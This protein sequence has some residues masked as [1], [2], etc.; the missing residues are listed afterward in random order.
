MFYLNLI[1]CLIIISLGV[2]LYMFSKK[3]KKIIISLEGNIGAGKSTMLSLLKDELGD[4]C[5]YVTEPVNEWINV[6]DESGKNILE[7]FYN[8]RTRWAYTFENIAYVTRLC[9]I[10]DKLLNSDKKYIIIDRSPAAGLNVFAKMSYDDKFM[11]NIEWTYLNKWNTFF[12][13]IFGDYFDHKIVYLECD[14]ETALDRICSRARTEEKKV[15]LEYLTKVKEYHDNWL[16]SKDNVLRIN[17]GI[18]NNYINDDNKLSQL[19][20]EIRRFVIVS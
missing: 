20:D 5:E 4:M 9:I 19:M 1:V 18:S 11:N 8:D 3:N 6:T 14:P 17:V 12:E 2:V 13:N 10:V 16:Q 7:N 15:P